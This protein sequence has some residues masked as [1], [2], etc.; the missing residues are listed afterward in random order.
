MSPQHGASPQAA[1][2]VVRTLIPQAEELN[3][4]YAAMALLVCLGAAATAYSAMQVAG[5]SLL[6]AT[7][8][9]WLPLVTAGYHWL[10]LIATGY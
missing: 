5:W 7:D 9:H 1:E 3:S 4:L 10:P 8:Y 2:V 6:I